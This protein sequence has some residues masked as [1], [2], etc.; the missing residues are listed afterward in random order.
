MQIQD[1]AYAETTDYSKLS[2]RMAIVLPIQK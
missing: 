1:K 2:V